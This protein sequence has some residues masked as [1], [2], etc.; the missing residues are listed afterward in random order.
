MI[1]AGELAKQ[2]AMDAVA[3]KGRVWIAHALVL[4]REIPKGYYTG[5]DIRLWIVAQIGKP[6]HPNVTGV[7]IHMAIR[8]GLIWMTGE[9]RKP[10]TVCSH[11]RLIRLYASRKQ[12]I[13]DLEGMG[14]PVH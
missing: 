14:S 12:W 4:L 9:Y 1:S 8:R 10:K 6:H 3:H 7:L 11:A 13:D 2:K 5:E